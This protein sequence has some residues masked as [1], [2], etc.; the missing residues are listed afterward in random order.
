MNGAS[1]CCFPPLPH[2]TTIHNRRTSSCR[3]TSTPST[4]TARPPP[5]GPF[6]PHFYPH[7]FLKIQFIPIFF[8]S[9]L[10]PFSFFGFLWLWSWLPFWLLPQ[11][12][13][14][15]VRPVCDIPRIGC[16][17]FWVVCCGHYF[18][19]SACTRVRS[20]QSPHHHHLHH[21]RPSLKPTNQPLRRPHVVRPGR[22]L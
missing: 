4:I 2:L 5:Y 15:P 3:C 9:P 20:Q 12:R 11:G 6:Y 22:V 13:H 19:T 8:L 21:H 16:P 7:F 1:F 18:G 10:I 14:A 17:F